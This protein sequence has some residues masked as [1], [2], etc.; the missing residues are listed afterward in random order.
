MRHWRLEI[1]RSPEG[2]PLSEALNTQLLKIPYAPP[3]VRYDWN[4]KLKIEVCL[5]VWCPSL[6]LYFRFT[7]E[8]RRLLIRGPGYTNAVRMPCSHIVL[9]WCFLSLNMPVFLLPVLDF[10]VS[11]FGRDSS[12]DLLTDVV[13]VC[14]LQQTQS[15]RS[16]QSRQLGRSPDLL[17]RLT[18]GADNV[19]PDWRIYERRW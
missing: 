14:H 5:S 10:L 17:L 9:T 4:G 16:H 6:T 18:D 7:G 15:S 3:K 11:V 2:G 19:M 1:R 12:S 13:T 8:S